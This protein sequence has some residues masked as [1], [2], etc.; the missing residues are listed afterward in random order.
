MNIYAC[1]YTDV[2]ADLGAHQMKPFSFPV[3]DT[4]RSYTVYTYMYLSRLFDHMGTQLYST[5]LPISTN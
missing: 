4:Y 2:G 5:K 3:S 1:A